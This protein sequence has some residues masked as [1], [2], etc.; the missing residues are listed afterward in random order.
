MLSLDHTVHQT[1]R[2]YAEGKAELEA[3]TGQ[4]DKTRNPDQERATLMTELVKLSNQGHSSLQV[5]LNSRIITL[6][7]T[8]TSIYE[9]KLTA[10]SV[11]NIALEH[12]APHSGLRTSQENHSLNVGEVVS[13]LLA[14]CKKEL[15]REHFLEL[16]PLCQNDKPFE[17]TISS[18]HQGLV[19]SVIACQKA[20]GFINKLTITCEELNSEELSQ[21]I[22]SCPSLA[23]LT[24]KISHALTD[25]IE[26]PKTLKY[27][28]LHG[29]NCTKTTLQALSRKCPELQYLTVTSATELSCV[30]LMEVEFPEQL[31]NCSFDPFWKTNKDLSELEQ[32]VAQIQNP[33]AVA[34]T[35]AAT[36]LFEH[37]CAEKAQAK[38]WFEL[39]LRKNPDFVPALVGYSELLRVGAYDVKPDRAQAKSLIDQ[40]LGQLPHQ[41]RLMAAK[42]RLLVDER[43]LDEAYELGR[44]I[45]LNAPLDSFVAASFAEVLFQ[46]GHLALAKTLAKRAILYNPRNGYAYTTQ[47]KCLFDSKPIVAEECFKAA[48][49][50]N[51]HDECAL[52]AL[53]KRLLQ[54]RLT[55][56][57]QAGKGY[58]ETAVQANPESSL[59]HFELA[60]LYLGTVQG[61]A[62]D[63]GLALHHFQQA[64]K[65]DPTNVALVKTYGEFLSTGERADLP[66]SKVLLEE[67]RSLLSHEEGPSRKKKK[68][69]KLDVNASLA[70]IKM[71]EMT[72]NEED[73]VE[74]LELCEEAYAIDPANTFILAMLGELLLQVDTDR[75][76]KY[77]TQVIKLKASEQVHAMTA[78]ANFE[79]LHSIKEAGRHLKAALAIAP[80]DVAVNIAYAKFEISQNRLLEARQYVQTA[81]KADPNS[82]QALA[83]QARLLVAAQNFDN[84]LATIEQL[85]T[86]SKYGYQTRLELAMLFCEYPELLAETRQGLLARILKS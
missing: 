85:L 15:S 16:S 21:I 49:R 59:A 44:L 12:L 45:Y 76:I 43:H 83:L 56:D 81:L 55:K 79:I 47:G 20:L 77:L 66:K 69:D 51:H 17:V 86:K 64:Y 14:T 36:A 22:A 19:A 60:K 41:V 23:S 33:S 9:S 28:T 75:G 1:V 2:L 26:W 61:V 6:Y 84:V 67:A 50:I 57:V 54:N 25:E 13:K 11:H 5:P 71:N 8:L 68:G 3:V 52:L 42:V 80:N 35:L 63:Y 65:H 53:A 18:H 70:A 74:A 24:I 38:A 82:A 10:P 78:L 27:V 31:I 7:E 32:A 73:R 58:L 29:T 37:E 48:V 46:K 39:A 30:E 4:L 34:L 40:K 62:R 72:G